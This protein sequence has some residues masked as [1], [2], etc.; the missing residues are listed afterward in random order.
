MEN[1]ILYR[2]SYNTGNKSIFL[3]LTNTLNSVYKEKQV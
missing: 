3:K 1:C 2:Y